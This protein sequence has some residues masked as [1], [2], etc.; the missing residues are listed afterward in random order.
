VRFVHEKIREKPDPHGRTAIDFDSKAPAER[1]KQMKLLVP[2]STAGMIIGK[3][4]AY[5]RKVKEESGAFVQVSQRAKEAALPERVVTVIGEPDANLRALGLI[6][7]KVEDD[8]QSANCL[9]ISYA[10]TQGPVANFDPTGSPFANAAD[11]NGAGSGNNNGDKASNAATETTSATSSRSASTV[12]ANSSSSSSLANSAA[13][14]ATAAATANN[15]ATPFVLP[16]S[17][18]GCLSLTFNVNPAR[19]QTD[20]ALMSQYLGHIGVSLR[21]SGYSDAAAEEINQALRCLAV[22]GVIVINLNSTSA[23]NGQ[24][25]GA[26]QQ[27]QQQQQNHLHSQQ[28]QPQLVTQG[29]ILPRPV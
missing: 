14:Q 8:P 5:V 22:H 6:L 17:T 16:L 1:E 27:Q 13:V 28:Q 20:P 25:Q 9:H 18:G 12:T 26:A 10:D 19:A 24:Q 11:K 4:G 21:N 7:A 3:A 15:G 23:G 29:E 2:N